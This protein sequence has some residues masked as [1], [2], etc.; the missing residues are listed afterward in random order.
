MHLLFAGEQI[1]REVDELRI[2]LDQ[3]FQTLLLQKLEAILL[4]EK[5]NDESR[6]LDRAAEQL[7]LTFK[8]STI[9]VPRPR[10]SPGSS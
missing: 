4:Q 6:M 10:S 7:L 9:F 8:D 1:D 5:T 2:P 3:P